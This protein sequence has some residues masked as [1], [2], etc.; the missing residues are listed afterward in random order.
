MFSLLRSFGARRM[1]QLVRRAPTTVLALA[2]RLLQAVIPGTVAK[3]AVVA[4]P[5]HRGACVCVLPGKGADSGATTLAQTALGKR[6]KKHHLPSPVRQLQRARGM[7]RFRGRPSAR[8]RGASSPRARDEIEPWDRADAQDTT[9]DMGLCCGVSCNVDVHWRSARK[10][11]VARSRMRAE[12]ANRSTAAPAAIRR[13]V[14]CCYG[15]DGKVCYPT[16]G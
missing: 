9:S 1:T 10:S 6:G 2:W 11:A 16:G 4:G 12:S 14:P 3:F 13:N 8:L 7:R 5:P 15:S